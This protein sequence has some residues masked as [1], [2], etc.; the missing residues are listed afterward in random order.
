VW[1]YVMN[2]SHKHMYKFCEIDKFCIPKCK[3]SFGELKQALIGF[4]QIKVSLIQEAVC[5]LLQL[6]LQLTAFF[7]SD[8]LTSIQERVRWISHTLHQLRWEIGNR[9]SIPVAERAEM[10]TS[11]MLTQPTHPDFVHKVFV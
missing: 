10:T 2:I 6:L 1:V 7:C 11:E 4:L 5:C 9:S 3:D 8:V